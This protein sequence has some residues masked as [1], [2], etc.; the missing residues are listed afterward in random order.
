MT[1][2]RWKYTLLDIKFQNKRNPE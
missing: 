2:R 1:T